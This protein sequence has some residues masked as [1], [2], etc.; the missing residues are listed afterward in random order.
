MVDLLRS[1]EIY[2]IASRLES[3]PTDEDKHAK[4]ENKQDQA[5]ELIE[6]SIDQDLRFH[7]QEIDSPDEAMKILF[8]AFKMKS[9][10][11]NLKMSCLL[12]TPIIS[13]L[14]KIFCPN[15]RPLDFF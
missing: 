13:P 7:I 15:S 2:K 11:T 3:K 6:M 5:R 10:P 9:K 8:L 14:L 4:W 12:W 1:K